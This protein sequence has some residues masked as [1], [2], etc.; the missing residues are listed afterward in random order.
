ME[1]YD[2]VIIGGGAAGFAAATK[3]DELKIKSAMINTDLP[4][5]GTC[6]NVGC[7]PSKHLLAVGKEVYAQR[8]RR[9]GSVS[10]VKPRFDFKRAMKDK[11][12]LI[13]ALR[14]KNYQDVL[15]SFKYVT[16]IDGKGTFENEHIIRIGER[17]LTSDKVL[18]ATGCSPKALSIDGLEETGYLTSREALSL[19]KKPASMIILGGSALGLEF[20]QIFNRMGSKVTIIEYQ[21]RILPMQEIEVSELLRHYLEEEGIKIITSARISRVMREGKSKAV[22]IGREGKIKKINADEILVAAGV[23]ANINDLGL[24]K[25]G[26]EIAKGRHINVNEYLQTNI[27]N[28]FAAGDCV[29]HRCLET[30]AAKEGKIAVE[31]AFEGAKKKIDLSSVPSAVFTDPEVASVGLTEE[32]YMKK[33]NTCNCRT[34][35]MDRVPKAL[36]IQDT[37]GLIKMII[38]HKTG[39][40]MGVHILS[41]VASEMIHEATLAIKFGLTIDDIID[42][43]HVFPTYSEAIKIVAQ[44]FRRNIQTM[45]CC[46]E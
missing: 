6:V 32:E 30:V 9:F 14:K 40:I 37:R 24:E 2:L 11:D 46:V 35:Y 25:I 13:K 26:L 16:W 36:A 43:L 27:P 19:Q 23:S 45:S 29:F 5:G 44:A 38:H 20:A 1:K 7:V 8:H 3:A 33:Y 42:T 4:M 12:K 34:V 15:K 39:R 28:I 18:I 10:P 41:P 22:I 31:N 21:E 17:R